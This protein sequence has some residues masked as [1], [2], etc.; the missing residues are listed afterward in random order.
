MIDITLLTDQTEGTS[1]TV[2]KWFRRSVTRWRTR[3]AARDRDG[4]GDRRNRRAGGWVLAE[5]ETGG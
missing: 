5:I 3:S 1:N 4:Q 2:G